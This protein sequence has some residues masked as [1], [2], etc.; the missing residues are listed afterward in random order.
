[1]KPQLLELTIPLNQ[2]IDDLEPDLLESD[3]AYDGNR[4]F[5]PLAAGAGYFAD[6]DYDVSAYVSSDTSVPSSFWSDSSPSSSSSDFGSSH[7]GSSSSSS[8]SSDSGGSSSSGGS[9]GGGD[10]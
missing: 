10:F 2:L 3:V 6:S 4:G 9:F 8:F 5:F 1:M 7:S